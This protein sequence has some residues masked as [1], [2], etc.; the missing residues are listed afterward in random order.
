MFF[1][2]TLHQQRTKIQKT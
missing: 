1:L 2:I